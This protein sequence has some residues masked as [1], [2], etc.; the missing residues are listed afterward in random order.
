[1]RCHSR[2]LITSELFGYSDGAFTGSRKGGSQGK[3]ELAD[4]GTIFLDEIGEIPLELQAAL[5]R[6]IEDKSIT[7]IGGTKVTTI[8]VRIIAATN[9]NLKEEVRKGKFRE[10]LYYRLNVFAIRMVPLR[11]KKDDI[12]LLVDCFVRNISGAMG[13]VIKTIEKDV[14]EKFINFQWPGNIRELQNVLETMINIAHAS[15]LTANLLPSEI[16]DERFMEDTDYGIE[17]VSKIERKLMMKMLKLNVTKKEIAKQMGISRSTLYRKLDKY[18]C[19][20]S[21]G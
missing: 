7:R 3:F 1:M 14:L 15:R 11:E 12:P 2:D 4:G 13:K 8:D 6:V 18:E 5:L 10:D 19:K 17:P 9:K 20:D 16:A 21:H